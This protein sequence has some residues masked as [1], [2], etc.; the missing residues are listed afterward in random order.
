MVFSLDR[1]STKAT[2]RLQSPKKTYVV[3]NGFVTAKAV[4]HSPNSGKLMENLVFMELVKR[5]NQPNRELFYYKTR[6]DREIDFVLKRGYKVVEL[7]QVCYESTSQEVE[8]REIKA[9]IEA[10]EELDVDKLIV[11]TW[12]EKKE[13]KRA[14]KTIQFTPLWEWLTR[15]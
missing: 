8:E 13:I 14:G 7:I 15:H 5:G 1:H 11:L 4:Q 10:S 2:M 3:D 6:N 9:L 12:N